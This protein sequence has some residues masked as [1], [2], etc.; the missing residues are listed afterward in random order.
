MAD[1]P[2]I[3]AVP[4]QALPVPPP[5]ALP[6][7]TEVPSTGFCRIVYRWPW[8]LP[9]GLLRS[10]AWSVFQYFGKKGAFDILKLSVFFM[11]ANQET[12]AARPE[13]EF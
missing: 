3:A 7:L 6:A 5:P 8:P 11:I 1:N 12:G 13:T 9:V 10:Q 2:T 4:R